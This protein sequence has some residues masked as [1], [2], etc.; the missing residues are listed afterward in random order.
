MT[1]SLMEKLNLKFLDRS[2]IDEKYFLK[3]DLLVRSLLK[4]VLAMDGLTVSSTRTTNDLLQHYDK[5]D[6]M[7]ADALYAKMVADGL[8][9]LVQLIQKEDIDLVRND[10]FPDAVFSVFK[11]ELLGLGNM[12]MF[13]FSAVDPKTFVQENL[14]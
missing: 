3:K 13:R 7:K 6:I 5:K 9:I 12:A 1:D 11:D 10:Y 2:G 14:N 8:I 4:P